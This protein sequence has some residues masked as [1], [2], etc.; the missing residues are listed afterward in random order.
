MP[1]QKL[2]SVITALMASHIKRLQRTLHRMNADLTKKSQPQDLQNH[3]A[4]TP[5]PRLDRI[6]KSHNTAK[7]RAVVAK[8]VMAMKLMPLATALRLARHINPLA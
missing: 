2:G 5:A 6:K 8:C 4:L 1:H 3:M 7:H